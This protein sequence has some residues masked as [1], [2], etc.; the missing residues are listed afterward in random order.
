MT[1]AKSITTK[2]FFV[3]VKTKKLTK[4]DCPL[5]SSI[6]QENMENVTIQDLLVV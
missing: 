4:E 3:F 5:E 1:E 6:E 2:S